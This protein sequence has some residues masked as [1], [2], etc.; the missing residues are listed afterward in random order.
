[1]T[2]RDSVQAAI[3]RQNA[4]VVP[5]G[6]MLIGSRCARCDQINRDRYGPT[7]GPWCLDCRAP[8]KEKSP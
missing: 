2:T 1:V 4:A 7:G 3:A 8:E 6:D 5:L